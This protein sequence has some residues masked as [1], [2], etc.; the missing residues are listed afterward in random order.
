[1]FNMTAILNF[2]APGVDKKLNTLETRLK[3][4]QAGSARMGQGGRQIAGG[5]RSVGIAGAVAGA[6]VVSTVKS[7]MDFQRQMDSVQAKMQATKQEYLEMTDLAKEMGST[8]IFTAKQSAQGLEFLAL[9]GFKAKDAMGVLPT[10]LHTAGAGALD[11]GRASDIIT[12]SMSAMSPV[13]GVFGDKTKQAI[14]LSDAMAMAQANSNTNIEQLGEAIKYGG[15]ALSNMGIPL[16]QIIS[17]MGALA[18]AGIKGSMGGTSLTNMM[19]KLAKPTAG[20]I[21]LME[22]MGM[23][24]DDIQTTMADGTTKMKSMAEIVEVFDNAISQNPKVLGRAGAA[25]E[26]FGKRGQRA[27]FA[28]RNKGAKDLN[29]LTDMVKNS[30]ERIGK[31][32]KRIAGAAE[33]QYGI[34]TDNLYGAWESVKSAVSGTSINIGE[35]ISKM[36]DVKGILGS[37]ATPLG[38]FSIAL[39]NALKPAKDW[40]NA[41]KEIMKTKIGQFALGVAEGFREMKDTMVGLWQSAKKVFGLVSG[42]EDTFKS[43]GKTI[44]KTIMW[45]TILGPAIIALGVGFFI[46]GP[47]V[48]GVV[49]VFNVFI[50]AS[51]ILY[52]SVMWVKGG[53]GVLRVAFLG[54]AMGAKI[55]AFWNRTFSMSAMTATMKTLGLKVATIAQTIAQKAWNIVQ[56]V[57]KGIM[58]ASIFLYKIWM[59]KITLTTVAQRIST[60][61]QKGWNIVQGFSIKL[62]KKMWTGLKMMRTAV[63]GEAGAKVVSNNVTKQSILV[64]GKELVAKKASVYWTKMSTLIQK[65]WTAT[66]ITANAVLGFFTKNI[67]VSSIVQ[68]TKNAVMYAGTLIQKGLNLVT[69]IGT[70]IQMLWN[71]SKVAAIATTILFV[72]GLIKMNILQKATALWTGVVTAAQWAWNV[73]MTMNPIGLVIM[74][75]GALIGAIVMAVIYW[76]EIVIAVKNAWTWFTNLLEPVGR[77]WDKLG[78]GKMVVMA[79]LGPVGMLV[80]GAVELYRNFDAVTN[81]LKNV[82]VW[83][84]KIA[85]IG[86]GKLKSLFGGNSKGLNSLDEIQEAVKKKKDTKDTPLKLVS[87]T[88]EPVK[89][90]DGGFMSGMM[91]KMSGMM[92]MDMKGPDMSKMKGMDMSKM[93][94]KDDGFMSGMMSKMS[95]MMGMDMKGPDMSKMKGMD[96]SK[97]KGM[98][99]KGMDMK[100]MSKMMSGSEMSPEMMKSM[101]MTP[102]MMKSMSGGEMSPE[103]MKAMSQSPDIPS[104]VDAVVPSGG[105]KLRPS[106]KSR[107]TTNSRK[108]K[109]VRKPKKIRVKK[110]KKVKEKKEAE[111]LLLEKMVKN[112]A[113][114]QVGS[115]TDPMTKQ[116]AKQ[117]PTLLPIFEKKKEK[118]GTISKTPTQSKPKMSV[119]TKGKEKYGT[120]IPTK[121]DTQP[122]I[123]VNVP[124]PQVQLGDV[125]VD[126]NVR[127]NADGTYTLVKKAMRHEQNKS[128]NQVSAIAHEK[129]SQAKHG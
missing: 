49:G 101:G 39:S 58:T 32:G 65:G 79:L 98:D 63:L 14:A 85:S 96:M 77:L 31:D 6:G 104:E 73:A 44:T 71:M 115:E 33:Q 99:M 121:K 100:G 50:G 89:K 72:A 82:W 3:R 97:M 38:K 36:F 47:I 29:K 116:T 1:M 120:E 107:S 26:I 8:T 15:G 53:L 95:G 23:S 2:S 43:F 18:D 127:Q 51:V 7:Y 125:Y 102:E 122:N 46:L 78:W 70:G 48:T 76:D 24:L 67:I 56:V 75:I 17:S 62:M 90:E 84:K 110:E 80:G 37:I 93:K 27:F 69:S 123:I 13:M 9:A 87:S 12:D 11:L 64:S 10:L 5:L 117:H 55:A 119:G 54:S 45:L 57:S 19:G 60:S 66:K 4:L 83:M 35:M 40:N 21:T 68:G 124:S 91:S 88:P 111:P 74:G 118:P 112:I 16:E 81:S 42:G 114:M 103:M 28:L 92:G 20:A 126:V 34:M 59:G 106:K 25:V 61:V 105:L 94:K 30:G 108:T 113:G 128:G 22:E 52:N 129:L 109:R 41:Q 86:L